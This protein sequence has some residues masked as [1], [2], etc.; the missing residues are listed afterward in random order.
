MKLHTSLLA[1]R[2]FG[3][4]SWSPPSIISISQPRSL[5][6]QPSSSE[7]PSPTTTTDGESIESE[8][9]DEF[10]DFLLEKQKEIVQILE[11]L[12]G[13]CHS[14]AKFSSDPW[15]VFAN[16]HGESTSSALS[17]GVT[18][19]IQG[20]N[21]IEKGACSMT[22]IQHGV[23]SAERANTIR[24]RQST[25]VRAGDSYSA[26]AL[27]MVLHTKSPLIPTFRSDVRIFMVRSPSGESEAVSAWFGGG[28]DLTPYYLFDDD[29]IAFHKFYRDLCHQHYSP[30]DQDKEIFRYESMK[31]ACDDY[32]YLPARQEHRG[33]GGIFFDDVP[34]SADSLA[35]TKG[36]VNTWMPSWIPIAERHKTETFSDREK[37][38]QLLRRGRYLEFNLLYDRGVKFG[39]ANANPRVEGVMVSAPPLIAYDYN[40]RVQPGSREADLVDIL[41]TPRSWL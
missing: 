21:V 16:E 40:H 18:R 34:L 39:L 31:R 13:S 30:T 35:F 14:D 8:E 9:F 11:N 4:S 6:K 1:L 20:G 10:V 33:T 5:E 22:L 37:K 12:E 29:I 17:G 26:A 19:V 15:G 2:L 23:L 27:S 7:T 3:V 25:E 38:W 41:Q 28:A 24:A 36:V 32:F